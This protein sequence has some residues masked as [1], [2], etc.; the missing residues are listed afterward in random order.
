[1]GF[2]RATGDI[3][4][5]INSDDRYLPH[6]FARVG[7][8]FA[9]HPKVG[10]A[11]S[12]VNHVDQNNQFIRRAYSFRPN[13]LLTANLGQN[14]MPQPGCFWRRHVYEAVGG[15]DA[16]LRFCMDLDLLIR[17]TGACTSRRIPGA[18]LAEF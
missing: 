12:D 9:Q 10:F 4:A 14:G 11:N 2:R 1:E 5:W 18:P 7:E 17:M 8:F 3:L 16:S 6:A 15:I 13:H